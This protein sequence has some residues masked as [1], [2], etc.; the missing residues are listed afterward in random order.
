MHAHRSADRL[1]V[2]TVNEPQVTFSCDGPD[3][4]CAFQFWVAEVE[5]FYCALD[6]CTATTTVGVNLTT[7]T[8]HACGSIQCSCIPGRNI[9]GKSGEIGM[10]L[11]GLFTAGP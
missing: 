2:E 11:I 1:I 6:Q 5:A 8:T 9:C 3:A 7:T 4:T 10:R